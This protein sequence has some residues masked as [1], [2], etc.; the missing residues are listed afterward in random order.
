MALW[1]VL[2][3]TLG[4][5]EPL[6]CRSISQRGAIHLLFNVTP[7]LEAVRRKGVFGIKALGYDDFD[8]LG[9]GD[10]LLVPPSSFE[11]PEGR[12]ELVGQGPDARIQ[13]YRRVQE[14]YLKQTLVTDKLADRV[15]K[16]AKGA[17]ANKEHKQQEE[18][19]QDHSG[20]DL[21]ENERALL[22]LDLVEQ[23]KEVAKHVKKLSA[24]RAIV[25]RD[26]Q[27]MELWD[28]FSRRAGP[29]DR[30]DLEYQ[31]D[32]F[33]NGSGITIGSLIHWAK[34][35]SKAAR[36]ERK[37][38]KVEEEKTKAEDNLRREAVK[39]GVDHTGG[40]GVFES[41]DDPKNLVA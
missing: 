3:E 34:E 12:H 1:K 23:L 7:A 18:K 32:S 9:Q 16:A 28:E 39:F 38:R 10:F 41:W 19:E 35:D 13:E 40:K 37:E 5:S 29:Y 15:G 11:S 26:G 24:D 30:R 21:T 6:T 8:I 14:A 20:D 25:D 17:G 2:L 33:K 31:W 36:E 4:E 22:D 27:G